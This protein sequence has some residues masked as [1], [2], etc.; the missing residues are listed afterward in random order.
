[1]VDMRLEIGE[2]EFAIALLSNRGALD[3]KA[4][5]EWMGNPRHVALLKELALIRENGSRMDFEGLKA[6]EKERLMRGQRKFYGDKM[7]N[8]VSLR[9]E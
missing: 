1:M 4:V 7:N 6:A 5:E 8:I 3:D 9:H 2:I